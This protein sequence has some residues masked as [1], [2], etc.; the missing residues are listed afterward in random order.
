MLTSPERKLLWSRTRVTEQPY[1]DAAPTILYVFVGRLSSCNLSATLARSISRVVGPIILVHWKTNIP[2][3]FPLINDSWTATGEPD[4]YLPPLTT[5]GT[6]AKYPI[7]VL[8]GTNGCHV[9][10]R[11]INLAHVMLKRD[12]L[13]NFHPHFNNINTTPAFLRGSGKGLKTVN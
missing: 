10:S 13:P 1:L 4:C 8:C 2:G 7:S 9:N 6:T 12:L 5:P 11:L 3:R